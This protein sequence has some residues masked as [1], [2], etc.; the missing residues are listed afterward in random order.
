MAEPQSSPA[1]PEDAVDRHVARWRDHWVDIAFDDTV[2]AIV[3]RMGRIMRHLKD[4]GRDSVAEVGLEWFEYDTLHNLM[5][6]DTPGIA[7]PSELAEQ[8]GVSAAGM[9]GRLD[10][11]EKA[12]YLNRR[13]VEGD[14]R[15]VKVEATAKGIA[16][17]RRA[18]T[19]RGNT[20]EDL[21]AVLDD[22][23]RDRLAATLKKLTLAIES[24]DE[25]AA[26]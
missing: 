26:S 12:G 1:G 9:T 25:S 23:E 16:V 10:T 8:T 3:T 24:V 22:D 21:V 14:R 2:E 4:A 11:L 5:I 19:A 6:S 7:S 18:I 20:E 15:R 17:W 13:A